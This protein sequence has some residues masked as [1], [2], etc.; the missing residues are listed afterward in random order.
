[1]YYKILAGIATASLVVI[2][3]FCIWIFAN[4]TALAYEL[5]KMIGTS[6]TGS[7]TRDETAF[8][9]IPDV[10]HDAGSVAKDNARRKLREPYSMEPV[11]LPPPLLP[12]QSPPPAP[13]SG[14]ART[15]SN[16]IFPGFERR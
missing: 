8:P 5:N 14:R 10:R 9:Q 6:P 12:Q 16:E 7:T 4:V 1:M 13:P 3:T 2:A 15:N 11:P